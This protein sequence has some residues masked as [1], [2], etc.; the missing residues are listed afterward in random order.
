MLYFDVDQVL[1][2][3]TKMTERPVN[4]L[5]EFEIRLTFD[6]ERIPTHVRSERTS[7]NTIHD[8]QTND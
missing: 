5:I 1:R 3:R 2:A 8:D 7:I 4:A 6:D